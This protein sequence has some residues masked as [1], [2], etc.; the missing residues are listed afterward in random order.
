MKEVLDAGVEAVMMCFS[1]LGYSTF[2]YISEQIK[3]PVLGHYAASG[4]CTEGISNG[5]GSHLAV[6]KFPRMAG[7]DLVMMNT[8]YGGYP[9]TRQQYFKTAHQLMLP[10]YH[11]NPSMPICGGGVHPGMVKRFIDDLGTDIVLA[12]GGAIQG[13]PMG[14]ASGV[15]AMYQAIDAALN[16]YPIIEAA[17]EHKE[18]SA[19]LKQFS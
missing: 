11:L 8:P 18:L 17:K 16:G 5:I 15:L 13:H 12:A 2:K 9:L 14:A 19:A 4:M 10:F 6:G 7:A 1:T 3:I